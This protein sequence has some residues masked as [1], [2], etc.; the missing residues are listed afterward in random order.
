MPLRGGLKE[1]QVTPA[2]TSGCVVPWLNSW[3]LVSLQELP[4]RRSDQQ[5]ICSPLC[6]SSVSVILAPQAFNALNQKLLYFFYYLGLLLFPRRLLVSAS[7]STW[8]ASKTSSILSHFEFYYI[9]VSGL[10]SILFRI[11]SSVKFFSES[12]VSWRGHGSW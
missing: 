6:G 7:N 8:A 3:H 1:G 11:I 5:D 12:P 4:G 9:L 2:Q 10:F